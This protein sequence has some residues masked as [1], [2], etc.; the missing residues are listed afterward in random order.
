MAQGD[1]AQ[2]EKGHG[3]KGLSTKDWASARNL[4]IVELERKM[5]KLR[6]CQIQ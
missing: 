3:T 2:R 6:G 1:K 4:E 5:S